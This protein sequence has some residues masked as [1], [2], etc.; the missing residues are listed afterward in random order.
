MNRSWLG[1][2]LAFSHT[3][4]RAIND[5]HCSSIFCLFRWS[6]KCFEKSFVVEGWQISF[7]KESVGES[8]PVKG[9]LWDLEV[10]Y[11]QKSLVIE[12]FLLVPQIKCLH[13]CLIVKIFWTFSLALQVKDSLESFN[14][15]LLIWLGL[16]WFW[17][18]D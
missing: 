7:S 17:L 2:G 3:T 9:F 6:K 12:F 13:E 1:L 4:W 15:K 11:T 14:I 18:G 5:Q 10:E 8:F 16:R